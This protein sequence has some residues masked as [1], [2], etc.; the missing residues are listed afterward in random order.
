MT[1]FFIQIRPA[2]TGKRWQTVAKTDNE[3]LAIFMSKGLGHKNQRG[4]GDLKVQGQDVRYISKS[5]LHGDEGLTAIATAEYDLMVGWDK[6]ASMVAEVETLEQAY[7]KQSAIMS[8][9]EKEDP[10][11]RCLPLELRDKL[12]ARA[13]TEGISHYDLLVRLV[14]EGLDKSEIS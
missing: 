14:Y 11:V 2:G 5:R 7:W 10:L 1:T 3:A 8:G 4:I 6:A 13:K 9:D 12:T